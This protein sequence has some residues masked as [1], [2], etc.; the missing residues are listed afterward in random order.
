MGIYIGKGVYKA[1][2]EGNITEDNL[3]NIK[4][5]LDFVCDNCGHHMDYI[6]WIKNGQ[7][8]KKCGTKTEEQEVKKPVIPIT[9]KPSKKWCD[10]CWEDFVSDEKEAFE[11]KGKIWCLDCL[12]KEIDFEEITIV[13]KRYRLGNV[14]LETREELLD[15][16]E[17]RCGVK[18]IK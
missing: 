13:S 16:M 1:I 14:I 11:Y 17:E 18:Q 6:G 10:T 9:Y 5:F 2:M 8:C 7:I 3:S 12:Q 15:L 4:A